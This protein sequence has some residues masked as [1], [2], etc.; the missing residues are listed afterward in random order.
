MMAVRQW[1]P[2]KGKTANVSVNSVVA[3]GWRIDIGIG[4][5]YCWLF[6]LEVNCFLQAHGQT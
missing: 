1:T 6:Q 4:I 2:W 5:G 3:W